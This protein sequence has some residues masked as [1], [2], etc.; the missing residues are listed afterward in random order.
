MS[1][2]ELA[3][4]LRSE[5]LATLLAVVRDGTTRTNPDLDFRVQVG[6][7]LVVVAEH[8]GDLEPIDEPEVVID[9]RLPEIGSPIY[10]TTA[11]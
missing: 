7:D 5:H 4:K 11:T 10:G 2:E 8:L 1:I 9:D 3:T 6:D